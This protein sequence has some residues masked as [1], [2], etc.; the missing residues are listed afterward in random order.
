MEIKCKKVS[1]SKANIGSTTQLPSHPHPQIPMFALEQLISSTLWHTCHRHQCH[2][3]LYWDV[4]QPVSQGQK[5][6]TNGMT[7]YEVCL[8]AGKHICRQKLRC[9]TACI[10]WS[11]SFT[12]WPRLRYW[13]EIKEQHKDKLSNASSNPPSSSSIDRLFCTSMF[14]FT[15]LVFRM[16]DLTWS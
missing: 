12:L 10:R 5:M 13:D 15:L 14:F 2:R 6:S 3:W 4:R 9:H 11:S 8:F 16:K 1:L 7:L